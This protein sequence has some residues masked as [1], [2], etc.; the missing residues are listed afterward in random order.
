MIVWPH[1]LL[2]PLSIQCD[3]MFRTVGGA[4]SLTGVSQA[5]ASDAGIWGATLID[6]PIH[7][8]QRIMVFHALAAQ[9]Q[10][11]LNPVLVSLPVLGSRTPIPPGG[12]LVNLTPFDDGTP[13]DDSTLWAQDGIVVQ[14][15]AA[16]ARRATR[17][18]LRTTVAAPLSAGQHFS[19]DVRL[20]RIAGIVEV[21]GSDTI[22]DIW[23]PLREAVED[24]DDVSFSQPVCKMKLKTD[25]EMSL[26]LVNKKFGTATVQFVEDVT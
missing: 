4:P 24:G 7:T 3:P 15:G 17:I 20:Y 2:C 13:F 10:G 21:T 18:T 9:I 22:V 16:A 8:A 1:A 12:S 14:I 23:P 25:Q 11:R 5:I 6:I 26:A 19:I